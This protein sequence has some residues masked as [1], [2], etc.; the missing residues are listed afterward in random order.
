MATPM[1]ILLLLLSVFLLSSCS[2]KIPES[3]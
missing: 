2:Q 1:K 3:K